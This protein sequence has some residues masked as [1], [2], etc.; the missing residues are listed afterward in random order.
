MQRATR[1]KKRRQRRKKKQNSATPK[2]DTKTV[3]VV[4]NPHEQQQQQQ[5]QQQHTDASSPH[6]SQEDGFTLVSSKKAKKKKKKSRTKSAHNLNS[7]CD[8]YRKKI[9]DFVECQDGH[10]QSLV[11]KEMFSQEEK[12]V[13]QAVARSWGLQV[14]NSNNS[15][16]DKA[17]A[18]RL[19]KP[20]G[21]KNTPKE[22]LLSI[23]TLPVALRKR[24]VLILDSSSMLHFP[25]PPKKKTET[26]N[27]KVQAHHLSALLPIFS[28]SSSPSLSLLLMLDLHHHASW[29]DSKL[30]SLAFYLCV[31]FWCSSTL[32]SHRFCIDFEL[33]IGIMESPYFEYFIELYQPLLATRDKIQL[34]IEGVASEGKF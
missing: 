30:T 6:R 5:N 24:F 18:L 9:K 34:F 13:I 20:P 33:P 32:W 23:G 15:G 8:V 19:I 2:R 17:A 21:W 22:G 29:N 26:H 10:Q 3:N 31:S 12:K 11:L 27:L 16:N 25:S 1:S 4:G 14:S 28:N 7:I